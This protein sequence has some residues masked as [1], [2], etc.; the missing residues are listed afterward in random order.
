[1][2]PVK[3]EPKILGSGLKLQGVS[4]SW[5]WTGAAA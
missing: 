3:P 1:M 4:A 5:P 2:R